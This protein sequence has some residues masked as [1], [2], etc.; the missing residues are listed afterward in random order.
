LPR[1]QDDSKSS[2][3]TTTRAA[4]EH[5]VPSGTL[6]ALILGLVFQFLP[7]YWQ[8]VIIAG[9]VPGLL[10]SRWI[11]AFFGGFLGVLLSWVIYLTYAWSVS[12]ASSLVSSLGETAG[13][14]GI[15]LVGLAILTASLLAGLGA[16]VGVAFRKLIR[17]QQ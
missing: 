2:T 3:S 7:N 6:I 11:G 14:P 10:T 12:P 15:L 9:L 1:N 17:R 5:P 13:I 8:L 16:I 4:S